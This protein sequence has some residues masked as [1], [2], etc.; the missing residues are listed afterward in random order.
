MTTVSVATRKGR[1]SIVICD[2]NKQKKKV[3]GNIKGCDLNS[4][5][6]LLYAFEI[7]LRHIKRYVSEEKCTS[8][9]FIVSNSIFINWVNNC[10]SKKQYQERF[11]KIMDLLNEIPIEYEFVYQKSPLA[12]RYINDKDSNIM[13]L[14]G[15]D[16]SNIGG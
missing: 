9:T 13:N 16:I 7:C 1:Y 14:S 6:E 8:V 5:D 11:I 2:D 15:L 3:V 12:L 4:Y 10:Y